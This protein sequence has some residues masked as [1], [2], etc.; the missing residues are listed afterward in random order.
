[1]ADY[2]D[3]GS[4]F[5]DG[6][7]GEYTELDL[8]LGALGGE[9]SAEKVGADGS[10][11][12]VLATVQVGDGEFPR[13]AR[14]YSDG[15]VG[16]FPNSDLL[17]IV[18]QPPEFYV[19]EVGENGQ[20]RMVGEDGTPQEVSFVDQL[21]ERLEFD[22]GTA[23]SRLEDGRWEIGS[24]DPS[25]AKTPCPAGKLSE[26][27]SPVIWQDLPQKTPHTAPSG[28]SGA[29]GARPTT[30]SDVAN[31]M[32]DRDLPVVEGGLVVIDN[33]LVVI[34]NDSPVI[35]SDETIIPSAKF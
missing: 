11:A 35:T 29:W 8:D 16:I 9:I 3:I 18:A 26:V 4:R 20:L 13:S 19:L 14:I 27:R 32:A 21:P 7:D 17:H 24:V 25:V 34:G 5:W 6:P 23:F 12:E 1:M 10:S 33:D 30:L 31:E 22:N 28:D 15:S 2:N